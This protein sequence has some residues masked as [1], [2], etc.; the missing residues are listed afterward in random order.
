[1]GQRATRAPRSED[2][3]NVVIH[4]LAHKID[5]LDGAADGTPPLDGSARRAWAAA[6]APAYLA[7][8]ERAED[9]K[10]SFLSDYASR[11]RRNISPSRQSLLREA[12]RPRELP[13]V[14]APLRDFYTLDLRA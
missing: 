5:F 12:R 3:Q 7:H 8:K 14:Y 6:F 13:D 9:G 4:E 10:T 11:T 2:G 1:M